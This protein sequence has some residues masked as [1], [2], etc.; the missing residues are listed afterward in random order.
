MS[1]LTLWD[2][3]ARN[4]ATLGD[5]RP[6]QKV[7]RAVTK[8]IRKLAKQNKSSKPHKKFP[9]MFKK[10]KFNYGGSQV[11][12]QASSSRA[13][14]ISVMQNDDLETAKTKIGRS[15][16]LKFNRN[17]P[18][19]I[20][21][22]FGKFPLVG[23][24]G[25]YGQVV[26][27][28]ITDIDARK[29]V[30]DKMAYRDMQGSYPYANVSGFS[31]TKW[32]D[33]SSGVLGTVGDSYNLEN[34]FGKRVAINISSKFEI[35]SGSESLQEIDVFWI[36]GKQKDKYHRPTDVLSFINNILTDYPA[37]NSAGPYAAN[38]FPKNMIGDQVGNVTGAQ[39]LLADFRKGILFK[40]FFSCRFLRR[41]KIK[42][43][44]LVKWKV[45]F[46]TAYCE[47][48]HNNTDPDAYTSGAT[49]GFLYFRIKGQPAVTVTQ[50]NDPIDGTKKNNVFADVTTTPG[51]AVITANVQWSMATK[52]IGTTVA[53]K[54]YN[55]NGDTDYLLA[56]AHTM[57]IERVNVEDDDAEDIGVPN[58]P[59]LTANGGVLFT[60]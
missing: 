3:I 56:N 46:P 31:T 55:F 5:N 10:R 4:M 39:S 2:R 42:P 21:K 15:V 7:I 9:K 19:S 1:T 50:V 22:S 26:F 52:P 23:K 37:E 34:I 28:P 14:E 27:A 44:A 17:H 8:N 36:K 45:L 11:S 43:G 60:S 48:K 12:S 13:K 20:V 57:A 33:G 30:F 59:S 51:C 41:F 54:V 47:F 29:L 25:V 32:Q 40:Q 18:L 6:V 58:I 16:H 49:S 35:I 24:C 38:R 53:K